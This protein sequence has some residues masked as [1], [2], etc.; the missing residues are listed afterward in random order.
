MMAPLSQ[1][2]RHFL[3]AAGQAS[4]RR[5]PCWMRG[6]STGPTPAVPDQDAAG[7]HSHGLHGSSDH[8]VYALTDPYIP[9]LQLLIQR[10]TRPGARHLPATCKRRTWA[11][12]AIR[13]R[14]SA[15]GTG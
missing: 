13:R 15:D 4:W 1:R 14:I 2:L 8:L 10:S 9:G 7:R 12:A 3:K 11:V 6:H 5:V